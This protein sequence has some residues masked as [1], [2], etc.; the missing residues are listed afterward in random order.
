MGTYTYEYMMAFA[1][2]NDQVGTFGFVLCI[3]ET[4]KSLCKRKK[5]YG[6]IIVLVKGC[7]IG[8]QVRSQ[9]RRTKGVSLYV[10]V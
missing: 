8:L 7:A 5:I 6:S 3:T 1:T 4:Q 9:K 10:G 2:T